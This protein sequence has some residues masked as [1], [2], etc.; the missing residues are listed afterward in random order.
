VGDS[1]PPKSI[2]SYLSNSDQDITIV[3]DEEVLNNKDSIESLKASMRW[4]DYVP[5][6]YGWCWYQWVSLPADTTVEVSGN[7]LIVHF[8]SSVFSSGGWYTNIQI[9]LDS[10]KDAAGNVNHDDIYGGNMYPN[11][12]LTFQYGYFSHNGR[13]LTL[14]FNRDIADNS[15]VG[16]S[17]T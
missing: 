11:Q 6:P 12:T 16:G 15:T 3:F 7:T 10:I 4:I 13:W 1:T 5:S 2:G 14:D 9:L 17:H 8:A